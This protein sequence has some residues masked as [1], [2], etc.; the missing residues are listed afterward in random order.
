[1]VFQLLSYE[2]LENIVMSRSSKFYEHNKIKIHKYLCLFCTPLKTTNGSLRMLG[3]VDQR[4]ILGKFNSL[5][6][7]KGSSE[8]DYK[9]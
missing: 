4:L 1:M 8:M 6:N 2:L 9:N 7:Y 5:Y 3:R